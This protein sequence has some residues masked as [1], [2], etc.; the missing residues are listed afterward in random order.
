MGQ[1]LGSRSERRNQPHLAPMARAG[2]GILVDAPPRP[3]APQA[4]VVVLDDA[5]RVGL[6]DAEILEKEF[7]PEFSASDLTGLPNYHIYLKL[8]IDGVVSKAFSAE[9]VLRSAQ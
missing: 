7:Y 8:M 6:S 2:H 1:H 9:S 3:H 5:F 4:A